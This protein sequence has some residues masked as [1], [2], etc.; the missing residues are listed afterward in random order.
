MSL[1]KKKTPIIKKISHIIEFLFLL[2]ITFL[3]NLIPFR[4][5][6]VFAGLLV[7][8]F[9]P[10]LGKLRKRIKNNL[11]FAYPEL[12]GK[13]LKKFLF[14]NLQHNFRVFL[15]VMQMRKFR[16][17]QFLEKHIEFEPEALKVMER[18][19]GVTVVGVEGHFGNWE[20]AIPFYAH[21]GYRVCFVA[22]HLSNP[23]VDWLL[24]RRRKKYGGE[25]YYMEDTKTL[26]A[27]ARQG[28]VLGLVADQDAGKDG[29]FVPFFGRKASTFRG[30]ALL[31]F[32]GKARF[33]LCTITYQGKGKYFLK[34]KILSEKA[35]L[36]NFNSRQEAFEK[37][38]ELWVKA[39]EEEVRKNPVQYFWVHRRWKTRPEGE[40]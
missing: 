31:A 16:K 34:T 21:F 4:F 7:F 20:L 38:T 6:H 12:K 30:P 2:W 35:S 9:Y 1:Y 17:K 40:V 5:L 19:K 18:P 25:I 11:S 24:H 22:K 36:E 10:F 29:I 13:E 37:L 27:L 8:L 23:Y 28:E 39:L 3:V 33:F 32:M 14:A 15:E 26:I